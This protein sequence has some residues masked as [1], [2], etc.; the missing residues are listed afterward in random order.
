MAT[1]LV[2]TYQLCLDKQ[3]QIWANNKSCHSMLVV[4]GWGWVYPRDWHSAHDL[5]WRPMEW[6]CWFMWMH[7]IYLQIPFLNRFLSDESSPPLAFIFKF[8]LISYSCLKEIILHWDPWDLWCLLGGWYVT[9][10]TCARH[11]FCMG[12][13]IL[14]LLC[15]SSHFFFSY[16]KECYTLY[17]FVCPFR[18]IFSS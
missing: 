6:P 4:L 10:S 13:T 3:C 11:S 7:E 5:P 18:Q 1:K 15:V 17:M 14:L 16:E 8:S 9:V 12:E 2:H